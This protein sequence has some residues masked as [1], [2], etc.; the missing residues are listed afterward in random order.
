MFTLS[1][2]AADLYISDD[3]KSNGGGDNSDY[4]AENSTNH[5]DNDEE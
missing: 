3:E 2:S 5:R 1:A 4:D